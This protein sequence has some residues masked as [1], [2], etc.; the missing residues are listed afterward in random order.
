M[1]EFFQ[2]NM[3]W[4]FLFYGLGFIILG[5][6]IF[7]QKRKVGSFSLMNAFTMLG[8]FGVLHG[9]NELL[10][11]FKLFVSMNGGE[12]LA[13]NVVR[14]IIFVTSF[15]FLAQFGVNALLSA[16]EGMNWLKGLPLGAG[17]MW[18]WFAIHNGMFLDSM[19]GLTARYS[20]GF[21][22][23]VLS[24]LAFIMMYRK[25]SMSGIGKSAIFGLVLMILSFGMYSIF[26]GLIINPVFDIR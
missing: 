15:V 2:N 11:M 13:L 18:F 1:S 26:G 4:V 8:W 17:M 23:G 16:R 24:T 25:L 12:I 19:A 22:G 14:N 5:V 20:L 3:L 21:V 9:T 7:I 10:D 6:T